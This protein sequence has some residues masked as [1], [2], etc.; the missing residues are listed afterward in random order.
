MWNFLIP[1]NF[2]FC[3]IIV[4]PWAK[5][6][7]GFVSLPPSSMP[8]QN[9]LLWILVCGE[10]RPYSCGQAYWTGCWDAWLRNSIKD[11]TV[12]PPILSNFL[13]LELCQQFHLFL[14]KTSFLKVVRVLGCT[15]RSYCHTLGKQ[16]DLPLQPRQ[17][18]SCI[19]VVQKVMDL[20]TKRAG[21]SGCWLYV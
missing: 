6:E 21:H 1:K 18:H 15:H 19:G 7:W 8:P 12:H 11:C 16:Q 10:V 3:Y 5:W 17:D 20:K 4:Q 14:N 13:K 2:H 9:I